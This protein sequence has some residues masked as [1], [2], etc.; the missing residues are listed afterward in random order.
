MSIIRIS[1][2]FPLENYNSFFHK[3]LIVDWGSRY[4]WEIC[5]GHNLR[6]VAWSIAMDR[7]A[8]KI[9]QRKISARG[10]S[11]SGTLAWLLGTLGK[12]ARLL[13]TLGKLPR[14]LGTLGKLVRLLGTFITLWR[15][16]WHYLCQWQFSAYV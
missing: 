11:S 7:I 6:N 2:V 9:G 12:L 3:V 13:R 15:K 16:F 5:F 4:K 10:F 14:L 1:T 8:T